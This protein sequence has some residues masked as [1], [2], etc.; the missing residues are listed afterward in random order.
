MKLLKKLNFL[1]VLFFILCVCISCVSAQENM[2]A[3]DGVKTDGDIPIGLN[4]DG[5]GGIDDFNND[6]G[7]LS[8][9]EVYNVTKDYNLNPGKNSQYSPVIIRND[10][11]TINGNGHIIDGLHESAFFKITGNNVKIFNLSFVNGKSEATFVDYGEFKINLRNLE[12]SPVYWSGDNGVMSDCQFSNNTAFHGG[13]ITW[14]GNNGIINKCVFIDNI[15]RGV[16]GAT[17]INGMNITI[18]NSMFLRSASQLTGEAIYLDKKNKA[19]YLD[20]DKSINYINNTVSGSK[21]LESYIFTNVDIKYLNDVYYDVFDERYD[22]VSILYSLVVGGPGKLNNDTE[23]GGVYN[24]DKGEFI[25]SLNKYFNKNIV[26][27][28]SYCFTGVFDFNSVFDKLSY[29][30]FKNN[31]VVTVTKKI[32]SIEDY[33]AARTSYLYKDIYDYMEIIDKSLKYSQSSNKFDSFNTILHVDFANK[34]NFRSTGIWIPSILGYKVVMID[35]H[36]SVIRGSYDSSDEESWMKLDNGKDCLVVVSNLR[37]EGFNSAVKNM[38]GCGILNNVIF[39]HNK[40]DYMV[41]KDWGGAIL[42]YGYILCNNCT[43]IDNYAKNGGAIFNL[44]QLDIINCTF[45]DNT[46]YG[47][48]NHICIGEKGKLT[49]NGENCTSNNDIA[50]FASELTAG[51]ITGIVALDLFVGSC[52]GVILITIIA[53]TIGAILGGPLGVVLLS[54]I[55]VSCMAVGLVSVGVF[56]YWVVTTSNAYNFYTI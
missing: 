45:H 5:I 17:Y 54:T 27:T 48:G 13:A 3:T 18:S 52:I 21:I 7:H 33:N 38:G 22:L 32:N 24:F 30:K 55:C 28:K 26:F 19:I 56:S 9:G 16:G 42:N 23:Y 4:S 37:L 25:L 20:K 11:I 47:R 49:I 46:A 29:G 31:F 50:F 12:K 14:T 15:A 34:M 53:G 1:F 8:P 41:K 51:Y 2:N 36:G 39:A 40:M 10:N 44:G 43:F 6:F 35:G